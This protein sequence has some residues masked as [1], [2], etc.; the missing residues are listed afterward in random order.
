MKKKLTM[1][2]CILLVIFFSITIYKYIQFN[3]N[4][5]NSYSNKVLSI[6]SNTSNSIYF[7]MKQDTTKE[8]FNRDAKDLISNLYALETI[9][10]SGSMLLT[11]KGLDS[12]SFYFCSDALVNKLQYNNI[13]EETIED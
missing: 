8:N 5:L 2:I 9:L 7:L 13:K 11:G 10:Y 3:N 12:N 4:R 6:A 1:S